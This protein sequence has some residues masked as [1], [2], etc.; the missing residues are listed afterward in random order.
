MS[1]NR[2]VRL[3][4][5]TRR[6]FR[7][8]SEAGR[9]KAAIIPTG[10]IEQH[11]EHMEMRH[12]IASSTYVAERVADQLYPQVVVAVPMAV[13]ISEHHMFAPGSLTAKPGS[14]L[15][16]MFDV[17]ETFIRHG[18][19]KVLILNGHGGNVAPVEGI[20]NQWKRYCNRDHP[21]AN[22]HFRS[23]W[24]L[25]PRDFAMDVLKSGNLPGHAQEFETAF[26][27]HAFPENVRME[28]VADQEDDAPA[29]ATAEQGK[30]LADKAVDEVAKFLQFMIDDVVKHEITG[31]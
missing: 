23:Y 3:E 6:E 27:L 15:A 7:E 25:I 21:G 10:S 12:D 24:D 14:W 19:N 18:V 22:L 2:T 5:M 31:L 13:G 1:E 26:A 29:M 20:I 16:V 4:R 28:A 8:A 11:L 30:Q 9:F 17:V